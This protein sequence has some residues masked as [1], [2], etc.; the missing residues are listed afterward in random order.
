MESLSSPEEKFDS[1]V[2][3]LRYRAASPSKAEQLY[4]F[5]QDSLPQASYTYQQLDNRAIKIAG[6]L[7]KKVKPGERVL[8]MYEPGLE[9]I[10]AFFGCLYA[11]AIAVPVHP[12]FNTSSIERL[13]HIIADC[14]AKA[15]LTSS[16]IKRKIMQLKWLKLANSVGLG[17]TI[18]KYNPLA[19]RL[20]TLN[21]EQLNWLE[22]EVL[23]NVPGE[24]VNAKPDDI[25]FLQYTSG[26][27]NQ[28]KGVMVSHG[29]LIHNLKLIADGY[30]LDVNSIGAIWLPPYHDMGLIGGILVPLY[31]KFPVYLS[32]P[33]EFLINPMSWLKTIH[34][35]RAT[36]SGGP[37][38][39]Y[40]LCA[41]RAKDS[42]IEQLD[43]SC[44]KLAFNGAEPIFKSALDKFSQRFKAA[45]FNSKAFSP[46]YGLAEA[47]LLVTV[48]PYLE[49]ITTACHSVEEQADKFASDDALST[50]KQQEF[51]SSGIPS[52]PLKIMNPK[53]NEEVGDNEIGEIWVS[54]D[55]VT[56][57]YWNNLELTNQNYPQYQSQRYFKTGDLGFLAEGKL[58]VTGR[59]KDM[60]IIRG[61]NYYPQDIESTVCQ[62][63]PSI[64]LGRCIAFAEVVNDHE[65]LVVACEL[66]D[67]EQTQLSTMLDSI[68]ATIMRE[69]G[70]DIYKIYVL[71]KSTIPK[72]LSGKLQR[73][74]CK[75]S[76]AIGK[77]KPLYTWTRANQAVSINLAVTSA[78]STVNNQQQLSEI[79]DFITNEIKNLLHLSSERVLDANVLLTE[80][81]ADSLVLTQL[82][83]SLIEKYGCNIDAAVASQIRESTLRELA[84]LIQAQ[85][86]HTEPANK[87]I[88]SENS[89]I[90]QYTRFATFPEIIKF[91]DRRRYLETLGATQFYLQP[92][93]YEAN[94]LMYIQDRGYI[95][96]ASYNYLGLAHHPAVKQFVKDAVDKYGT[97]A[98]ASRVV[99]GDRTVSRELEDAI[100]SLL[101]V[102]EAIIFTAG[103]ATVTTTL[104]H[105][106]GKGDLIVY[107]QLAHNSSILG[108]LYSGAAF[109]QFAHNDWQDL[110]VKLKNNRYKY[111]KVLVIFE[112]IYSMDGDIPPVAQYVELKKRY[113]CMLMV[114]EA[115]SIGVLGKNGGGIRE[116]FNLQPNDIDIWMGTISK[117]F[118]SCGG[119]IAGCHD[120]IAYLKYTAPG[121]VFSAGISPQNAAAALAAIQMMHKEPERIQKLH[122]NAKFFLTKVKEA[123]FNT[124]HSQD[125]PIIPIITGSSLDAINLSKALLAR[126]V[127]APPIIAPA[128]PEA[129]AR[130][131]FFIRQQHSQEQL[132]EAVRVLR[133]EMYK[134]KMS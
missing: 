55:S 32:S 98:S 120:L 38:F 72:T 42:D 67:F 109:L 79:L 117:S 85:V 26:S 40:Q 113:Q 75:N 108:T 9:L 133:E 59:I 63:Y 115:H 83:S 30:K 76:L 60:I 127:N 118:A 130:L 16:K 112:G 124:G 87:S 90:E 81:I 44:W 24:P 70:L 106:F 69:H 28:P 61:K 12:P 101:G 19:G 27:T 132:N 4:I 91:K 80:I 35:Y 104:T 93:D 77:F 8:I 23:P 102:D 97:S 86:N 21:L 7:Q 103:H 71:P 122:E 89:S 49:G 116:H 74:L 119:Y 100:A 2:S 52:V 46:T 36:I 51:I 126:N 125:T 25:A 15:V 17:K 6:L 22:T 47:T 105:L 29:N 58:H 96:F 84:S 53:T 3:L 41:D 45:K 10:S 43:L 31:K 134:L 95:N 110:E 37:N 88:T 66:K 92:C 5:L 99:T 48:T 64:R 121:F 107:D 14:T 78:N 13:E 18:T 131:R 56:Q 129:E 20:C 62:S 82:Y 34:N 65:E 68:R 1:L 33:Q 128:V 11:G 50:K 73:S 123:G 39:A 54:G 111:N 94:N 114:D 57:G